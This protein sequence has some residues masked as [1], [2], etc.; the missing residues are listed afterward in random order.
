MKDRREEITVKNLQE[1]GQ[2]GFIENSFCKPKIVGPKSLSE[3]SEAWGE[4]H[5]GVQG[6]SSADEKPSITTSDASVP[7]ARGEYSL[8]TM[9]PDQGTEAEWD[10]PGTG[11]FLYL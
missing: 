9:T 1:S 2:R 4:G 10:H 3:S 11:C 5:E 8:I 6:R 7:P